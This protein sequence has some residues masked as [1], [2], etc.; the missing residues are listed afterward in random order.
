MVKA[1][2][3]IGAAFGDEGKGLLVDFLSAKE[4]KATVVVRFNGGAQAGHTVYGVVQRHSFSHIGAGTFA[5][6]A[7]YLSRF[8]LVNPLLWLKEREELLGKAPDGPP[9]TRGPLP[10]LIVDPTALFTTPWDM[11]VNREIER[12]RASARHGSCGYGINET[13]TRSATLPGHVMRAESTVWLRDFLRVAR[14][15]SEE[16]FK[17]LGGI[18]GKGF[19][20]T[21]WS[22]E[23]LEDFME[24]MRL[25]LDAS[26]LSSEIP[27]KLYPNVVFEGAQG[28]LLDEESGFFPHVTRSRTGLT[29]VITLC[30]RSGI[31]T[32]EL[33]VVYVSRAYMTRHGAGPFP[34]EDPTL[35]YTDA[36]NAPNEFQGTLRFGRLDGRLIGEAIR[37]D[38]AG[39]G[40]GV[41]PT[42][43]LTC[44]DQVTMEQRADAAVALTAYSD[45]AILYR[46]YGPMRG[47]VKEGV[48]SGTLKEAV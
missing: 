46:S 38:L 18:P 5:G 48:R 20:N 40:Y 1:T 15:Y 13:V 14:N 37:K 31:N 45:L 33:D 16:R 47:D 39:C 22:D 29:N 26:T 35:F 30:R 25:F 24:A 19:E 11:L 42:L 12:Q 23:L 28:L 43:A 6:A 32:D 3:V 36:T 44:L 2:A 7:T 9:T 34:T 41:R 8:F 10:P 4:P 21:F 27:K 17:A